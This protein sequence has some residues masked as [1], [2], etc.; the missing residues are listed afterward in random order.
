MPEPSITR[1]RYVAIA[2]PDF[3]KAADFYG[4]IWGLQRV[5]GESNLAYFAAEGSPEQY[6]M[7][8]RAA[9]E[10]RIDVDRLRSAQRGCRR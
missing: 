7:R 6:V 8:L 2:T 1:L 3:D 4:G 10:R 9:D 5:G